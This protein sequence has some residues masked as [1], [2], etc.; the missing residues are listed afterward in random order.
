M[1]TPSNKDYY[2]I[3]G[4]SKDATPEDIKKAFRAKARTMHP[5]VCKEPGAEERFKE[6]S[7]AYDTLSA[8]DKKARYDAVK[9]GGFTTQT[10]YTSGP[11][12]AL[13]AAH[14]RVPRMRA[15]RAPRVPSSSNSP[16]TR[17]AKAAPSVWPTR[18]SRAARS[19]AAGATR[20]V[21]NPS[22]VPPAMVRARPRST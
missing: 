4:V 10:P 1:A 12:G 11:A 5:D 21:P 8:P 16:A 15:S 17:P 22:P 19:A 6:V 9:A 7:E 14:R 18:I 2:D 3:L 13:Q 20:P